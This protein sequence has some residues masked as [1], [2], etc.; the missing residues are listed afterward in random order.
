MVTA[1][2]TITITGVNDDPVANDVAADVDENGSDFIGFSDEID[3]YT[4]IPNSNFFYVV[5]FDAGTMQVVPNLLAV[6][7]FNNIVQ[8]FVT[9]GGLTNGVILN[10]NPNS[11]DIE[12]AGIAVNDG[13][14]SNVA[15]EDIVITGEYDGATGD[16]EVIGL[17]YSKLTD[18]FTDKDVTITLAGVETAYGTSDVVFDLEDLSLF[19]GPG[20]AD[21]ENISVDVIPHPEPGT[22]TVTADFSDVDSS[23]FTFG[24]DTTGTIGSVVNNG[25]G[26]FTYST[27]NQFEHLAAGETTTDTFTYTVFDDDGGMDTATATVTVTGT[28]DGPVANDIAASVDENA[29]LPTEFTG[30]IGAQVNDNAGKFYVL[31]YDTGAFTVIQRTSALNSHQDIADSIEAGQGG[32][33]FSGAI[34]YVGANNFSWGAGAT[35]FSDGVLSAVDANLFV[36]DDADY[37]GS[38]STGGSAADGFFVLYDGAA[39][40]GTLSISIED[41]N[42]PDGTIDYAFEVTGVNFSDI[43]PSDD[44][45]YTSGVS[46]TAVTNP[47]AGTVDIAADYS[48]ID[49]SDTHTFMLD[50]SE[51]I[52]SVVNNG[53]GTFTYSTDNQFEYLNDTQTATDSFTYTVDD[54]NGGVDTA[55]VTLTVNGSDDLFVV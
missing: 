12:F 41:A 26:T 33:S 27:D 37:A 28:N 6:F 5:D 31:N 20:N 19:E 39:S 14:A 52:G 2:A 17:I 54:G 32:D 9:N 25:D 11:T 48:D 53:D 24:V 40:D 38:E 15:L 30:S 3:G 8:E 7:D 16:R 50:T 51:T 23:S 42:G 4:F 10:V 1:N 46:V 44:N 34:L 36:L 55:T 22:V 29:V 49:A 21:L 43:G 45:V 13:S 18:G 47:V 35:T